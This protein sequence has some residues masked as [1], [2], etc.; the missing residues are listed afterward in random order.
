M[1][2]DTDTDAPSKLANSLWYKYKSCQEWAYG[3]WQSVILCLRRAN[4]AVTDPERRHACALRYAKL[5]LHVDLHFAEGIDSQV[6]IWFKRNGLGEIS[7]FL[8][9]AWDMGSV[10]ILYL[11][12]HG[13]VRI[14]TV[15]EG[16]IYPTW[17]AVLS[18]SNVVELEVNMGLF[19]VT[20]SLFRTLLINYLPDVEQTCP[21]SD[22]LEMQRLRANRKEV[23]SDLNFRHLVRNVSSLV[24]IEHSGHV[25]GDFRAQLE[26]LRKSLCSKSDFRLAASRNVDIVVQAF[27]SPRGGGIKEGMHETLVATL[28]LIFNDEEKEDQDES[29]TLLSPW[30][31]SA[32][33]AVTSFA[34]QQMG[35]RLENN[36]THDQARCELSKLAG[37]LMHSAITSQEAD[38]V[39]EMAKGVS[40]EVAGAVRMLMYPVLNYANTLLL[41][42]K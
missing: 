8:T 33:A 22:I 27:A 3:V 11:V 42:R 41:V 20:N 4:T 14:T 37:R 18:L 38:F 32:T 13:A 30:K 19:Q 23:Y 36:T 25:V 40:V 9:E 7:H 24:Y 34:L 21:P 39:S 29:P 17:K 2:Q 35:Q 15:L 31:L 6:M 28:R 10:F 5:L 1:I 12:V 16:I 26:D